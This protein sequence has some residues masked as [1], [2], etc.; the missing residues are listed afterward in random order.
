MPPEVTWLKLS[1]AGQK[2]LGQD[3]L[4]ILPTL[5]ENMLYA[6]MSGNSSCKLL[7]INDSWH[8]MLNLFDNDNLGKEFY[9]GS[10]C[11]PTLQ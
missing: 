3:G 1:F 11:N 9:D 4:P 10:C 6:I 2:S 8:E 7:L 5:A